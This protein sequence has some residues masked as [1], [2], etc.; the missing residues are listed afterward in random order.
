[1]TPMGASRRRLSSRGPASI[2][3]ACVP[4]GYGLYAKAMEGVRVPTTPEELAALEA[5]YRP[6]DPV[7]A[8]SEVSCDA[9]RWQRHADA[10]NAAV[11]R[12][13]PESWQGLR[14][15]FLRAAALDSSALS[16]L[17]RPVPDLTAVVL[18]SSLSEDEWSSVVDATQ[19]VVEC[20]RRALVVAS[21]AAQAG[22]PVDEDLI[23]RLQDLIVESQQTYTVTIDDGS[24]LE[25]ELPRR[26]YK[27]VSNYLLRSADNLVPFAPAAAVA[28]E[29]SRLTVEL[30]PEAFG[31]LHPVI[32]GAYAHLALTHIHP[33]ADGNGR[34]ARTVAS[35]PFLRETGLPQL[36]LADQWPAYV[37]ALGL[38][39]DGDAQG[40][41]DLFLSAQ[42]NTMDL[43]RA[44]LETGSRDQMMLPVA[45][46]ANSPERTL[47]EVVL[48]HLRD[49]IGVPPPHFRIAV[50]TVGPDATDRIAVR[51]AV[52][53]GGRLTDLEFTV[54]PDDSAP[55]WLQVMSSA[56]DVIEVW[57]DDVYPIPLEIVHLR[58]QSWLNG[59]LRGSH[60]PSRTVAG[61]PREALPE[62]AP[63]RGLFVLGVPRSGTT[64]IGNYIGSHPA[65]LGLA[66]YG[67]FYVANSVAPAYVNRLPGR[68]HEGFL[69]A[70]RDLALGQAS[71]AAREQGC[72]WFCDATPWNLEIAGALG[73]LL[74]DAVF[75]L[76]LRH[77]SGAL[78]SLRQFEW[79]GHSWEEA[80]N[81]WVSLNACIDQLPQDR[82]VVIGYDAF[83]AH[84]AEAVAGIREAL[85]TIGLDPD[86]FDDA[87]FAASHAAIVG[88]PRP[89]VATLVDGDVVF[90]AI[91]SLEPERWMPEVHSVVWPIVEAMHRSLLG[92]FPE[93]YISP[94]RPD[95]VSSEEW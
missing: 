50:S 32:Q 59:V 21:D 90:H 94:P 3:V 86:L 78:L 81:L 63:V 58:V 18:R 10:L 30:A 27:P 82:T 20:H 61:S 76:M 15:R 6:F 39:D 37:Q 57:R 22:R 68:Q 29:M 12:A 38:A 36:I 17:I 79:A 69:A 16:E 70:L 47:L 62:L 24:K 9:A 71:R 19:L 91:P 48:V 54:E 72:A 5:A 56:G 4:D 40:V 92:R 55:G 34:L 25:V 41:I 80:A 66:E 53:E 23:A 42:V 43:A 67:G 88:R 49:A 95:H 93:V 52:A 60:D 46:S 77:F 74:P 83:T 33:F 51:L 2:R 13:D 64:L 89:T 26:Q 14:D 65:V 7:A 45:A 31:Q 73:E 1:M 35:I 8:W 85:R 28:R 87:Q 44:L 84:P 11:R 75:M